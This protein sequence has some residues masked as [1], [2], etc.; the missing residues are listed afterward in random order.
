MNRAELWGAVDAGSFAD[1]I[2][3]AYGSSFM[4]GHARRMSDKFFKWTGAEG[5][6]RGVRAVAA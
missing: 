4:T 3:Q 1:A 2:G 6:N 5:W